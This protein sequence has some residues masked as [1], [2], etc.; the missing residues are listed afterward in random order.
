MYLR[1][2]SFHGNYTEHKHENTTQIHNIYHS[3]S[4]DTVRIFW[5][6]RAMIYDADTYDEYADEM[7]DYYNPELDEDDDGEYGLSAAERNK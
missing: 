6:N 1:A 5:R 7:Y 2:A 3:R 4:A